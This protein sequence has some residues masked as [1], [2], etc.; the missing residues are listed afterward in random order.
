M[1]V[2]VLEYLESSANRFPEKE[3]VVDIQNT[4]TYQQL[5][6][7]AMAIGSFIAQKDIRNSPVLI[8]MDK[9]V[10]SLAAFL[11]TVYS[12]NFYVPVDVQ[13]PEK[14]LET[15]LQTLK[16]SFILTDLTNLKLAQ[17]IKNES[18]VALFEDA[19][20]YPVD[21]QKLK[22]VRM[23][24]IDTDPLY[25][26]FTSGSTGIPKGVLICHRS[27]VDLVEQFKESFDF[28]E[29]DIFG[30]QAPFDFDVS[31]KDIY[32]SLKSAA[33]IVII[34]KNLFSFPVK[35]INFLNQYKITV[36]IWAVSALSI[37]ATLKGLEKVKPLYLKKIMFS[38]EVMPIKYLNAWRD[39]LPDTMFVNLYGPTEITCNCT[40]KIVERR[41]N[42]GEVVPIGVPFRNTR[43]F[44]LNEANQPA[45]VEEPG[46]L[47][48]GGAGL[49][50]G[51]FNN[52]E[53]TAQSF[54]QNPLNN[55][56][57]ELIYR[58]GDVVEY[59]PEGQLV[60]L[61]RKDFQIKH[62][63]HRIELQEIEAAVYRLSQIKL[64]CCI[65]S[66]DENKIVLFY[67][68]DIITDREIAIF[69]L[70]WLPKYMLPNKVIRLDILPMNKNGKIDRALLK[71]RYKNEPS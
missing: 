55:A 37:V 21:M 58:T 40:Y 38:G 69:L 67:E 68:G 47:Y 39:A 36:I 17:R 53:K 49:A 63:G 14:R 30:N 50:L 11:G 28:S 9:N 8:L 20:V 12:G 61:C 24:A 44:V 59:N 3:A 60:F 57:P 42:E 25:C 33:T 35:L 54:I 22:K 70:E 32:N 41:Y 26:I 4:L 31:V 23:S 64:C 43:I 18:E 52:P 34:P 71:E 66:E 51:Y 1:V 13:M 19:F 62:M 5:K 48:V 56:Y 10:Y 16:P 7:Y 29:N 15:I 2:N 46:E 65:Y 45:G 27:V 6:A